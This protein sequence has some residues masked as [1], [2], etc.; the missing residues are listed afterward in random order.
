MVSGHEDRNQSVN[1]A[2]AAAESWPQWCPAMKTGISFRGQFVVVGVDVA[3]MVS[4]HEDR[5]QLG[6]FGEIVA[7]T[8]LPQWC[9]AMKTGI[10]RRTA[11][12]S[13]MRSGPQWCPAMKTGIRS[14][15]YRCRRTARTR[16]NGVRP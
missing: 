10:R 4:G 1:V 11:S 13:S 15:K 3:S 7:A 14:P 16:L 5:N 12:R 2:D 6:G 8:C 9:P